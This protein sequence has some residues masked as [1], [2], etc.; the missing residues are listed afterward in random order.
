MTSSFR[1]SSFLVIKAE[2]K[3]V[4]FRGTVQIYNLLTWSSKARGRTPKVGTKQG[5]DS[6]ILLVFS[7]RL[8]LRSKIFIFSRFSLQ[9]V[10]ER[11]L[12]ECTTSWLALSLPWLKSKIQHLMVDKGLVHCG[13]CGSHCWIIYQ[14]WCADILNSISGRKL[15]EVGFV[16]ESLAGAFTS[17]FCFWPL[18]L[19]WCFL[20]IFV[21]FLI[22]RTVT[23]NSLFS[24][25]LTLSHSVLEEGSSSESPSCP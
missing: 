7:G 3:G 5:L 15:F 13:G 20:C 14:S 23:R 12:G 8:L 24:C 25:P 10:R 6:A 17:T 1:T 16:L 18:N 9:V 4:V 2:K 21:F 19:V 22:L 11:P